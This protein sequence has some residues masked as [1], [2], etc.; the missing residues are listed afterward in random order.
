MEKGGVL[1]CPGIIGLSRK[2]WGGRALAY[3]STVLGRLGRTP[4]PGVV[5]ILS[6]RADYAEACVGSGIAA[7]Q[8][9]GSVTS[10]GAHLQ[11]RAELLDSPARF[12]GA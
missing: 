4:F 9:P 8:G 5:G 1:L 11:G 2:Q 10:G 6:C 12:P 7:T 3:F